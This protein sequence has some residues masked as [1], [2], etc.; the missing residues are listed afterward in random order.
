VKTNFG[1]TE[2]AAGIAGLIKAAL[3]LK[4][5]MVPPNLHLREL[6]PAIAWNDY[7]LVIP[8]EL[9]RLAQ[10]S[11]PAVAGVSA[12]GITGTNA[13][14]VLVEARLCRRARI[15]CACCPFPP[16]RRKRWHR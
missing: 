13:H 4:H 6:N 2:G 15:P 7:P 14:V 9:T 5:R 8:R 11:G 10:D 12:F 16:V 3:V 1:H